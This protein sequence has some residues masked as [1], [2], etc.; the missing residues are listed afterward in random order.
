MSVDVTEF[1][2]FHIH[3]VVLA[4]QKPQIQQTVEPSS[5]EEQKQV[6]HDLMQQKNFLLKVNCHIILVRTINN[7]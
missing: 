2:S 4:T 1:C 7:K 3:F 6:I 5:L